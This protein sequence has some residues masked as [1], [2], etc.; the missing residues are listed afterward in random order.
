MWKGKLVSFEGIDGSGK[1]TVMNLMSKELSAV[2]IKHIITREPGGTRIG[3]GLR[4]VL[5]SVENSNM[6]MWS[7]MLLYIASRAQSVEEV[8]RPALESGLWV[9]TD[10]FI[11]ST[12]A[13][14]GFGRGHDLRKLSKIHI[15]STYSMWP[16]CTLLYDC[17]VEVALSRLHGKALDR[18]EIQS[19]EFFERVRQGYL[20][21]AEK[22]SNRFVVIDASKGIEE[23]IGL[24]KVGLKERG[25]L[26]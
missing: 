19:Y 16:D 9:L 23:V 15:W 12:L 7:E 4:S 26:C 10:R 25:L 17:A 5:L 22:E 21:L 11:D 14:Q 13:Y 3:E 20:S 8:V 6:N 18:H 1:S 24:S 2:G